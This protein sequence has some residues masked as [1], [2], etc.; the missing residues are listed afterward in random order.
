M[1]PIVGIVGDV[2]G[3]LIGSL[4]GLFT[5]DDERL[6]AKTQ[7]LMVQTQV[8]THVLDYEKSM[9]QAQSDIIQSEAKGESWVQRGWRPV[10]M[11][12]FVG[13]VT[14]KWFGLTDAGISE[15]LE[16]KL[17]SIIQLGLGGYVIGRSGE[18]IVKSIDFG[19]IT[20]RDK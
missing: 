5:S 13:I 11:L 12:I 16:L 20:A 15:Q 2:F 6:Q 17:M 19:K 18:K 14:A 10:T 3:K 8:M 7:I 9:L 4:D 1:S